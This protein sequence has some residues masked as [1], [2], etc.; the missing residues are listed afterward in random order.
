MLRICS[1]LLMSTA[2]LAASGVLADDSVTV[3]LASN[4][5]GTLHVDATLGAAVNTEF[6]LDTG[7][8]YVVLTDAT[9][10]RLDREGALTPVRQLRAV[11]ANNSTAR[12]QVY[13]VSSLRLSSGCVVR[14]FE[15]VALPGARKDI[16]GLSA[17]RSVA[18]FTVHLEPLHLELNC[19]APGDGRPVIA[20]L[21]VAASH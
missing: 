19:T 2:M 11:M 4:E 10:R 1:L 3:A 21:D 16:L 5:V 12:A 17:L 14:D 18:P 6:L 9:R 7:S 20:A 13:R 8:A 15:A